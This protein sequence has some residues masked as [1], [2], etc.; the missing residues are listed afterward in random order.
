MKNMQFK[1]LKQAGF[2]LAE[3]VAALTISA[4]VLVTVL[5]VYSRAEKSVSAVTARL[6]QNRMPLEILQRIAE[7]LDAITSRSSDT[8]ITIENK[9]DSGFTIARLTILQTIYD[10][11]NKKEP[12]EK[13]VWQTGYDYESDAVG[14]VLYRSYS[15]IGLEEKL[16]D[17]KKDDWE[18]ELFIPICSG[19]TFF[20]VQVPGEKEPLDKWTDARVPPAVVVTISFAEPIKMLDGSFDVPENEKNKRTIAIDRTRKIDFVFVKKEYEEES[21]NK[22]K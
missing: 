1:L 16:L 3:A 7:D 19:I 14:L 13:I 6:A 5:A 17:K 10:G 18:R 8:K 22:N 21:N 12:L 2:S 20:K 15:G 4:M 9:F 11:K